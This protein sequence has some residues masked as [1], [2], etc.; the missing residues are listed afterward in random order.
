MNNGTEGERGGQNGTALEAVSEEREGS[1]RV[2]VALDEG[3]PHAG[4]GM[5]EVG[6]HEMLGFLEP[7]RIEECPCEDRVGGGVGGDSGG[8]GEVDD[9]VE[10]V[11]VEEGEEE[12]VDGFEGWGEATF[13][14][15]LQ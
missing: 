8:G 12:A 3:V 13:Q 7:S 5:G 9:E 4:L 14:Q 15:G 2:V 6:H 1:L 10:L 11:E